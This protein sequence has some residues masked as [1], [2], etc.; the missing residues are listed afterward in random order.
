MINWIFYTVPE[1]RQMQY[2]ITMFLMMLVVPK[3]F[4][5]I[6][7]TTLGNFINFLVY[8]FIYYKM[9]RVEE[10]LRKNKDD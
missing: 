9:L 1:H 10:F 5:G 2:V 8:D 3:Y 7:F 6:Q 4:F